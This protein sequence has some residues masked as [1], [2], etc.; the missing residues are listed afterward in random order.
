MEKNPAAHATVPKHEGKERG[1]WTAEVLM[2]AL[3]ICEDPVLK[4]AINL[5][6]ACSLRL[7]EIL[8]LTWDCVDLSEEAMKENEC[9]L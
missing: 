9:S 8:G 1:I 3:E 7:G 6:F 4:V 5:S 2:Y